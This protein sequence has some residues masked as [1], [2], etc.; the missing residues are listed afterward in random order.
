LGWTQE[1]TAKWFGVTE[2]TIWNWES[3]GITPSHLF[4][5]VVRVFLGEAYRQGPLPEQ[6]RLL[7]WR[8]RITQHE[9]ASMLGVNPST[10]EDWETGRCHPGRSNWD[11]IRGLLQ[12]MSLGRL[13]E[14]V[15]AAE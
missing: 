8:C 7:R 12:E 5:S 2:S 3:G 11:R 13:G 6:L 10:V 1:Q 14:C 15:G 4:R 9:L